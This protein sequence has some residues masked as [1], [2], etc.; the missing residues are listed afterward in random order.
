[1]YAKS[2]VKHQGPKGPSTYIDKTRD[3]IYFT[4]LS[5]T[6]HLD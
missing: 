2:K 5:F 1:M 4:Q 6:G 3:K